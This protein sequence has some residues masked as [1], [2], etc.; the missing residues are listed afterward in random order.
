MATSASQS[1]GGGGHGRVRHGWSLRCSRRATAE[2]GIP[3]V[4]RPRRLGEL[5]EDR[6]QVLQKL[7]GCS[8]LQSAVTFA[9]RTDAGAMIGGIVRTDTYEIPNSGSLLRS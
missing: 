1:C 6:G 5:Q 2:A 7:Q 9:R 4:A 8:T 3:G